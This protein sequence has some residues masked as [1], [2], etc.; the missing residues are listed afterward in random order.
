VD[1]GGRGGQGVPRGGRRAARRTPGS[2]RILPLDGTA[3]RSGPPRGPLRVRLQV[4]ADLSRQLPELAQEIRDLVEAV[5]GTEIGM[6]VRAV[7]VTFVDLVHAEPDD[8]EGT[9]RS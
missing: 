4:A 3:A 7:D 9:D 6:D 8:A 1:R 2:C 5:A